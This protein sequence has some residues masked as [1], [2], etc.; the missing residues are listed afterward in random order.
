[1]YKVDNYYSKKDSHALD[2]LDPELN[3]NLKKH[4]KNKILVSDQDKNCLSLKDVFLM[5][6]K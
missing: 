3:L 1:M 2:Y 6:I 5:K 4:I